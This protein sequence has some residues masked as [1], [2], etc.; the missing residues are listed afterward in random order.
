MLET[1][2]IT[3]ALNLIILQFYFL[4]YEQVIQQVPSHADS[5]KWFTFCLQLW[6]QFFG[7]SVAPFFLSSLLSLTVL[8]AAEYQCIFF[9]NHSNKPL[10]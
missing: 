2:D 3:A 1:E 8:T 10:S 6:I 9:S 4:K 5:V 7:I